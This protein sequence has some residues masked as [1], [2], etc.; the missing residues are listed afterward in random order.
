[1]LLFR[2][3][4]GITENQQ[5]LRMC[6]KTIGEVYKPIGCECVAGTLVKLQPAYRQLIDKRI[7]F[8][9]DGML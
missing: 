4:T 8:K 6:F 3:H 1:M 7:N 2:D 9:N 5:L